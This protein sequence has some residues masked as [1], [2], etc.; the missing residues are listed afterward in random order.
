MKSIVFADVVVLTYIQ[1]HLR[2][3]WLNTFFKGVTHLGD[4]GWL[5]IALSL[6]LLIPKT[7][8]RIGIASL[9]SLLLGALLTNVILKNLIAR[10]RPFDLAESIQPLIARPKDYSFPSGHTCASFAS[11]LILLRM[12]PKKYGISAMV[13]A[14][15]I[16]ISRMYLG[17]HYPTDVIGGFLVALLASTI[18]YYGMKKGEDRAYERRKRSKKQ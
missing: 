2:T 9:L 16:A 5:W 18:V 17:V 7:T 1:E 14:A 6:I 13:L 15:L 12:T 4:A 8:R 3:E 10:P 11:A